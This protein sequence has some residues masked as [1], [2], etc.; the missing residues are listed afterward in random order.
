MTCGS[1]WNA[2]KE[3]SGVRGV[4]R[5]FFVGILSRVLEQ[6]KRL[7]LGLLYH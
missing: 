5:A 3:R 4:T 7:D 2:A 1:D 6:K